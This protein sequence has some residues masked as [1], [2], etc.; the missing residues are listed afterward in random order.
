MRVHREKHNL[1]YITLRGA[2][3]T[4]ATILIYNHVD[5]AN[6]AKNL[7]HARITT[8]LNIYTH[9]I[10]DAGQRNI[11]NSINNRFGDSMNSI[12]GESQLPEPEPKPEE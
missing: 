1:P 10:I 5:I 8:T 2:R 6:V 12:C 11:V 3:H 9:A 4:N 7:G